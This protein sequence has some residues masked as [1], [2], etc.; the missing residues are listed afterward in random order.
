MRDKERS[1][2]M[3][4]DSNRSGKL[5]PALIKLAAVL[6]LGGVAP[7]L[8]T[9]VVNVGLHAVT[10]GLGAGVGTVQWVATAYLL[11]LG[12]T[13]P[14]SGWMLR[15]WGGRSV[16]LAGLVLFLVGSVLAGLA[17]NIGLLIAF[18]AVQGVAAG[19]LAPLVLTLLIQ[20]AGDRPLGRLIT[21]VTIVVVVV[22]IAGPVI[23][24]VI[25]E[26]LSWRWLFFVNI[27]V[28]LA[29]F[30]LAWWMLHPPGGRSRQRLDVV[31][32]AL[33]SPA[34]AAILFGLS[35]AGGDV[36]GKVGFAQPVVL[37]PVVAGL[38]A[39]AAFVVWALRRGENAL[40]DLRILHHRQFA[41]GTALLGISG[42]SLY[43]AL[44][45]LPLYQQVVH[46]NDV[47]VAGL[48]LAPQG[49]GALL[50][51]PVGPLVDR[52]G[53]RPIVLA[54][55]VLTVAG[56]IP[57]AL[58]GPDT[59]QLLL[60]IALVVRGAGLSAANIGMLTASLSGL[61]AHE[62]PAA[63]SIT[64]IVQYVGGAFGTGVLATILA[65]QLALHGSTVAAAS[66]AFSVTFWWSI[67]FAALGL[68]PACFLP[69]RRPAAAA[70]STGRAG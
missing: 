32:L 26:W 20:A 4:E 1:Y 24:G 48:L 27:P 56:T 29:A 14:L 67:A 45:L 61:E 11:A 13:V 12:V 18:R 28:T 49:V 3:T 16:W 44:L 65:Q 57:Y 8:D 23:G 63:G 53:A 46:G 17:P 37:V 31:G 43:A 54:A 51:R 7:Q 33:L 58:S 5:D 64:R 66:A 60:A 19:I 68:I 36:S 62:K 70:A 41:A 59:S 22:P 50:V 6:V 52:I 30:V 10:A 25:V 34:L 69:S 2:L 15:R 39:G 38:V 55:T 9:T 35:A 47:L 40:L 42:L 21:V